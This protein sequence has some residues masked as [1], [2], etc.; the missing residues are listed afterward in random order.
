M[1]D[2]APGRKGEI[3]KILDQGPWAGVDDVLVFFEPDALDLAEMR[4]AENIRQREVAFA[5]GHDVDRILLE[6][7]VGER[8]GMHPSGNHRDA[9]VERLDATGDFDDLGG[10]RSCAGDA[11]VGW[12][13][14]P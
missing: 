4:G 12:R 5:D 1:F 3:V 11:D 8:G 2:K 6:K 7:I 10:K 13:E 9:A 14:L